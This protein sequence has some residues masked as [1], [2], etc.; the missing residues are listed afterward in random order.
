MQSHDAAGM[1]VM[2]CRWARALS[3][4]AIIGIVLALLC[5]IW[6]VSEHYRLELAASDRRAAAARS[7]LR[8]NRL[9]L[10]QQSAA[11][12]LPLLLMRL[13]IGARSEAVRV[14]RVR[15]QLGLLDERRRRELEA[16]QLELR[17]RGGG[18]I[19]DGAERGW[20]HAIA[21]DGRCPAEVPQWEWKLLRDATSSDFDTRAAAKREL[22][23]QSRL[24]PAEVGELARRYAVVLAN[25]EFD[26][27]LDAEHPPCGGRRFASLEGDRV[28]RIECD[29]PASYALDDSYVLHE[30]SGP[31]RIGEAETVLAFCDDELN[32]LSHPRRRPELVERARKLD[33][34]TGG[35]YGSRRP[36]VVLFMI[37]AT[38]R[39]H[40]RRSMPKTLAALEAISLYGADA[41]SV[42]AGKRAGGGGGSSSSG[43]GGGG[44]GAK[45]GAYGG[46]GRGGRGGQPIGFSQPSGPVRGRVHVFDYVRFN[47]V[48]YNSM[49]NQLPLYCDVGPDELS[50]L[51]GHRCVWEA[52]KRAGAVT[53]MAEEIHDQCATSTTVVNALA[54]GAYGVGYNELPDHEWWKLFC[55]RHVKPCCWSKGGFL[56]PG[57]RQCVGGSRELH[58][59][60]IGYLEEFLSSYSD[61]PRKWASVNTM[62]AHEHFMLRLPSLDEDMA[63]MLLRM[64]PTVLQDTVLILLS[65]HGTHGIWYN[66]HEIG[67][68]EHQLP[69]LY[70]LAPDWLMQERPAWLAALAANQRRLVTARELYRAMLDLA[71]YPNAAAARSAGS[72]SLFDE[73]PERRTCRDARI[74]DAYCA[75]KDDER[76]GPL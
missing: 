59:V 60:I 39:A 73:V 67:A 1:S 5:S 45:A 41:P 72:Y 43:G 55:S 27:I 6:G 23:A 65:D 12:M 56:N 38:S 44:E 46:D 49:P 19:A 64:A 35:A 34:E 26:G 18:F 54:R 48:G 74:P 4:E 3:P 29:E 75:C 62:V 10:S 25:P 50:S 68:A 24:S 14:S 61:A 21:S 66:D 9:E 58:Q 53:M 7:R 70:V 57:R 47:V 15:E 11:S 13:D 71:A 52:F 8:R 31:V 17:A 36:S 33:Q 16:R 40:F 76:K 63:A 69:F 2:S 30:Y 42:L 32:L 28:L 22:G 20:W 51:Q 37:D